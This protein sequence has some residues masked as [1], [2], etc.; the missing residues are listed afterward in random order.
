LRD[1]L[2]KPQSTLSKTEKLARFFTDRKFLE[3]S[4]LHQHARRVR[5]PD[6]FLA[7]SWM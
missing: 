5:Y 1:E 2:V 4:R 7:A 6:S 3:A